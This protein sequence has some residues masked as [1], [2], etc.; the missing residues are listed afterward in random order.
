MNTQY[1]NPLPND[2]IAVW[3]SLFE[4]Q[5]VKKSFIYVKSLDDWRVALDQWYA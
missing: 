5:M 4:R 1:A 3:V 2:L